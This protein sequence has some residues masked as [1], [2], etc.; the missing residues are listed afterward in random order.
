VIQPEIQ[1]EN[2]QFESHRLATIVLALAAGLFVA[3]RQEATARAEAE[4]N[5]RAFYGPALR[6]VQQLIEGEN[7]STAIAR[8]DA[9]PERLRGWEWRHVRSLTNESVAFW[10]SPTTVNRVV[11]TPSGA[12]LS[13]D[14]DGVVRIHDPQTLAV[15]RE[16]NVHQKIVTGLVQADATHIVSAG[17]DNRL[18]EWDVTSGAVREI[19]TF[20]V[21]ATPLVA[22]YRHGL[23]VSA[24]DDKT[25]RVFRLAAGAEVLLAGYIFPWSIECVAISPDGETIAMLGIH[26]I[27]LYAWR[28]GALTRSAHRNEDVMLRQVSYSADGTRLVLVDEEAKRPTVVSADML[29]DLSGGLGEFDV[30]PSELQVLAAHHGRV[31]QSSI[32]HSSIF[33][34]WPYQR[35]MHGHI[36]DV[37]WQVFSPDGRHLVSAGEDGVRLWN[38][39]RPPPIEHLPSGAGAIA[40]SPDGRWIVGVP[41]TVFPAIVRIWDLQAH[42]Q[43]TYTAPG[44]TCVAFYPNNK[45]FAVG[46]RSGVVG[47]YDVDP[48]ALS[49]QR[50]FRQDLKEDRDAIMSVAVSPDGH[51]LAA[52]GL[53]FAAAWNGTSDTPWLIPRGNRSVTFTSSGLLAAGYNDNAPRSLFTIWNALNHSLKVASEKT[54]K[55]VANSLTF[56]PDGR[57]VLA[58]HMPTVSLWDAAGGR[59]VRTVTDEPNRGTFRAIFSPDGGR[60]IMSG[61]KPVIWDLE[62]N[63]LLELNT[64]GGDVAWA[65]DR[66]FSANADEITVYS[67]PH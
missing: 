49:A 17:Y 4:G 62:G 40:A 1:R 32:L 60:I 33:V 46:F 26:D 7:I 58:T 21:G 47:I 36:E 5:L 23:M 19:A 55:D 22:D 14:Y 63:E 28:S 24:G 27:A 13:G 39:D 15:V 31:A 30:E 57:L 8:L 50:Q 67:A 35:Q 34:S 52:A 53:Y 3:F 16:V 43:R 12:I 6:T 45:Q 56:S 9:I 51:Q 37:H 20:E 48:I 41:D 10:R 64:A 65:G 29:A 38:V 59:R 2:Q 11:Y 25:V 44:A 66:V 61:A 54:G 18:K 42:T